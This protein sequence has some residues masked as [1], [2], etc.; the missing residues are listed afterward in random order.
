MYSATCP[1]CGTVLYSTVHGQAWM[2]CQA[3]QF[4]GLLLT[5]PMP[6]VKAQPA[7]PQ[8]PA[9]AAA[10]APT[11]SSTLP[12]VETP[13]A[14]LQRTARLY[15]EEIADQLATLAPHEYRLSLTQAW[16]RMQQATDALFRSLGGRRMGDYPP[17][18]ESVSQA[19]G[20]LGAWHVIALQAAGR[21]HEL[22]ET[23]N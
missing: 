12:E 11:P 2:R 19:L 4:F 8:V 15:G 20:L 9:L 1:K 23:H 3:C 22:S 13:L 21:L 16:D 5:T 10:P 6:T 17:D 18:L 7:Q 14:E